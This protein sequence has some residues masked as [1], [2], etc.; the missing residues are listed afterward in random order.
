MSKR[1]RILVPLGWNIRKR[2]KLLRLNQSM[3]G[4]K[5]GLHRTYICDVERGARNVTLYTLV[6]ISKALGTTVSHLTRGI[7]E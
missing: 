2:R 3:L 7:P 6:S 4:R 1:K 5:A